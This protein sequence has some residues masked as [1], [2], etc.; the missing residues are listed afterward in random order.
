MSG[1][2]Q[3]EILSTKKVIAK[4]LLTNLC[5][6][7][8]S[9]SFALFCFPQVALMSVTIAPLRLL[10]IGLCLLLAWPL[11]AIAVGFRSEEDKKEP[12][13]GWRR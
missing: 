1:K 11:A 10:L 4:K 12:L 8:S 7:D 6:I 13:S 3:L 9:S 2:F 5:E